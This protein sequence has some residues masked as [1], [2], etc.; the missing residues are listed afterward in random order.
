MHVTSPFLDCLDAG[1][2]AA[3]ESLGTRRHAP[4]GGYLL[5]EG[6]AANRIG[7]IHSGLVK[8]TVGHPDGY[9]AVLAVVGPGELLGEVAAFDGGIRSASASAMT[10]CEIQFVPVTEFE[11][12]IEQHPVIAVALVRTLAARLRESDSHRLSSAADGVPRRLARRL[13]QLGHDHGRLDGESIEIDLAFSQEDLAGLV[14][15][16]RDA[17]AKSLRAWREQGFVATRRRRIVLVDPAGLS[18]QHRL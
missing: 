11:R 16:S 1:A 7:V 9:E 17:V 14:G 15:A 4:A 8:V 3:L 12:L 6:E 13:L 5:L 18:R 10:A 2:R